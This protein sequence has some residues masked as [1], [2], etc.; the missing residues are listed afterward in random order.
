MVVKYTRTAHLYRQGRRAGE[1]PVELGWGGL[2]D[3]A[4]QGDGATP[5]GRYRVV[6]KKS[7]ADTRF[8]LALLLD[9]PNTLDRQAF[10]LA[11]LEGEIR[12]SSGIGGLIE[13]HG[14]GGQGRDW[15]DGCVAL[16]N[17]DMQKVFAAA[18]QGMPV[19]I[20]GRLP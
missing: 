8:H 20:V 19:T 16:R 11:K 9:Y 14:E 6:A 15:T 17:E 3:K 12:E 2:V 4:R 5:E 1:F 13:V 7:G 18:Y 10:R